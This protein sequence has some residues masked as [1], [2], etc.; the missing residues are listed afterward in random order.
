MKRYRI[1]A[2][3]SWAICAVA[4][5]WLAWSVAWSPPPTVTAFALVARRFEPWWLWYPWPV[6]YEALSLCILALWVGARRGQRAGFVLRGGFWLAL[7]NPLLV[8]AVAL[9]QVFLKV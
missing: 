4:T 1:A 9:L 3:A 6:W 8:P 5:P 2:L 7:A